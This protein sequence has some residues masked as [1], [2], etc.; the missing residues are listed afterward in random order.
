[1]SRT[2]GPAL[3]RKK[4]QT[5]AAALARPLRTTRVAT[6]RSETILAIPPP[7]AGNM[8]KVGLEQE[9]GELPAVLVAKR[10]RYHFT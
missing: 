6:T 5:R 3:P 1:M 2:G 8:Q 7:R 9:A 10:K 4:T